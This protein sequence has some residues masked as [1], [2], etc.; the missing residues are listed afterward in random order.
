MLIYDS[1]NL[2]VNMELCLTDVI[3]DFAKCVNVLS[4][5]SLRLKA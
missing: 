3:N 5:A 2:V 1:P 4:Y